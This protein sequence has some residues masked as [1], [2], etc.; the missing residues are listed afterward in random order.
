VLRLEAVAYEE[1][2][3]SDGILSACGQ[4]ADSELN[5]YKAPS[6]C[7]GPLEGWV[8]DGEGNR[9][10]IH[11]PAVRLLRNSN[12]WTW[13]TQGAFHVVAGPLADVKDMVKESI[14]YAGLLAEAEEVRAGLEKALNV[15]MH[16]ALNAE[17]RL[18]RIRGITGEAA[19][20]PP[21]QA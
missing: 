2:L 11:A 16:R 14:D 5:G 1:R 18:R 17:A 12:G 8:L 13:K 15:A 20:T 19:E 21:P 7:A 3:F 6:D 10:R 9:H 4:I